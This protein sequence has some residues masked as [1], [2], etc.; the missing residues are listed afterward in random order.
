MRQNANDVQDTPVAAS[1][2]EY[3]IMKMI[4]F[5][6]NMEDFA[7]RGQQRQQS[8]VNYEMRFDQNIVQLMANDFDITDA[9]RA[10]QL[11]N[12]DLRK[13]YELLSKMDRYS[14]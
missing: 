7:S 9:R 1:E 5:G 8:S 2:P 3:I 12:N 13:A 11:T 6:Q 14:K 10:L 4:R